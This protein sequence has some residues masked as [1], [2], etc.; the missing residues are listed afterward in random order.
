[1]TANIGVASSLYHETH[2]EVGGYEAMREKD[3][4]FTLVRVF[5][6]T[7]EYGGG[8]RGACGRTTRKKIS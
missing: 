2:K 7:E 4:Y 6:P 1:M 5:F 8:G 3:I